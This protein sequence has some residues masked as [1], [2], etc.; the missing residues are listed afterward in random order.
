MKNYECILIILLIII[1]LFFVFNNKNSSSLIEN[2]DNSTS[3][4]EN[5]DNGTYVFHQG[6]N[7]KDNLMD[8]NIKE[9]ENNNGYYFGGAG[10]P[11]MVY[12][13]AQ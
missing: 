12:I 11:G 3:L 7:S 1:I 6:Y 8:C 9:Y 13:F 2:F 5:I 4:K 10:A